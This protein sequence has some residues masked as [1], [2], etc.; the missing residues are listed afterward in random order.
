[1]AGRSGIPV[2]A[3]ARVRSSISSKPSLGL[4]WVPRLPSPKVKLTTSLPFSPEFKS[5]W[6]YHSIP[7]YAHRN[8]HT[9]ILCFVM[10][11]PEQVG[12]SNLSLCFGYPE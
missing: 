1:M 2:S 10:H 11:R 7:P 12:G 3:G 9:L 4:I 6:A 5:K 8:N